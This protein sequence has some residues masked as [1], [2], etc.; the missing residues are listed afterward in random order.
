MITIQT[1]TEEDIPALL[2]IYNDII[3]HTTA[4][5]HEEPHTL[6]MREEW[7]AIKK[8]Q[9]FPVFTAKENGVVIGFSTIGPFRPWFGYRFTVE[10]SVYVAGKSRGKGVA[11]LLMPPLIEAAKQL[12]LH[13]I[14]AGIEATNE[15]SIALHEKFGFVEVAHFK[16]V[17]FKFNRWMDLKFLELIIPGI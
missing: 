6:A 17:G 14:V 3:I 12:G 2:E 15:A 5:W 10:N 13:A 16:E 7:F 8:E 4:V 1:A 9:G 11:K